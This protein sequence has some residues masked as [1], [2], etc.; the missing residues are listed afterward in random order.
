VRRSKGGKSSK[1]IST[2]E[3]TRGGQR[4]GNS[5]SN[6][7]PLRSCQQSTFACCWRLL[8]T[9]ARC[10]EAREATGEDKG[11]ATGPNLVPLRL[12]CATHWVTATCAFGYA[13]KGKKVGP[14]ACGYAIKGKRPR[15]SP[16]DRTRLMQNMLADATSKR[17][18]AKLP[19]ITVQQ[20]MLQQQQGQ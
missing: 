8:A 11:E 16:T 18:K 19:I 3:G 7:C 13:R 5:A 14:C 6:L 17:A 2:A 4:R 15:P 20:H 1:C 12:R 10:A 9:D